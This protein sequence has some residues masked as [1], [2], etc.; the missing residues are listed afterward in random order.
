MERLLISELFVSV[1]GEG[2]L[3]GIPSFFIRTSG[4]NLRCHFCD[5]PYASWAPVGDWTEID[6]IMATLANKP[7]VRHVVLTGGEPMMAKGLPALVTRLR[8][9]G[10]HITVETA[11]TIFADL[12]V[13]LWSLSP[14]LANST[15]GPEH[16]PWDTRHEKLRYQP[17]VIR[18]FLATDVTVQFKVVASEPADLIEI[19]RMIAELGVAP[20]QVL[21]MPEGTSIESLNAVAAWLVPACI[22]RGWR[23]C[24]RM[25]IRLFGHMPGT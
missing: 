6:A 13:D 2:V 24:D 7:M 1:Q 18:Q 14:K 5:T 8:A 19:E 25:H 10:Y 23:F 11:A 9:A 16:A 22:E 20:D 12:P 17:D 3:T 15:P 4:C 21:A